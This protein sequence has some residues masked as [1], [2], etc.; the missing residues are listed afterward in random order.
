MKHAIREYGWQKHKEAFLRMGGL[1]ED[2]IE[3]DERR[4]TTLGDGWQFETI[5]DSDMFK[6]VCY[7]MGKCPFKASFDRPCS[8]RDRVEAFAKAG[9]PSDKWEDRPDQAFDVMDMDPIKPEEW[10]LNPD[11]ARMR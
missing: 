11:A 9:V 10:L 7:T 5:A 2:Y 1:E 4:Y 8:I 6:P 3:E